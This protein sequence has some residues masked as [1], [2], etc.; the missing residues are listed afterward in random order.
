[1]DRAIVV[2]HGPNLHLLGT[3]EPEVYGSMTLAALNEQI[4]AHGRAAGFA[5][6]IEQHNDEG[7]IIEA[8]TRARGAEAVILNPGAYTHYS[9][10]IRDAVAGVGVPTIEVHISNIAA[11]ED[12]R[13]LSVV[14]PVCRGSVSGF[15]VASYLLAIEAVR[16]LAAS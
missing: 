9:Y 16:L 10:A 11:R 2:I 3:R 1:M 4:L 15:G 6:T 7:A 8:L 5:V 12:F 14:A 13:R